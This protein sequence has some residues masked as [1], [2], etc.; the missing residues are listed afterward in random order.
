MLATALR[1]DGWYLRSDI[2]WSKKNPMPEPVTDRPTKSHEHIFLLTKQQ[3]YYYDAEAIREEDVTA[4]Q[5]WLSDDGAYRSGK[6]GGRTAEAKGRNARKENGIGAGRN[7]RDVWTVATHAY[8]DAHF[9]TFPEDLIRP[10]V[11]AGSPTRCCA[12]CGAPWVRQVELGDVPWTGGS[13]S[14]ARA[15]HMQSVSPIGQDPEK[16]AYNTGVMTQREH[17][18]T[19]WAPTCD[20]DGET[21]P[22]TVLD[23]FMG[24]GTTAK[25]AHDEGR[26]YLGAELNP[27]YV[28]IARKR[29]ASAPLQM[30]LV[31]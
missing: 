30:Q 1:L 19:G 5:R 25:V 16:S 26:H 17:K 10:C 21:M 9:A 14:G 7:K 3:Q 6:V 31:T 22:G 29:I 23:P 15:T 13:A 8:P 28:E 11:L 20:H 12:E 4:Q 24:S 18:T 27:E 2:I